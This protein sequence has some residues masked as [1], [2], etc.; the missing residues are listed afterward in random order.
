MNWVRGGGRHH[1]EQDEQEGNTATGMKWGQP[2][3]NDEES[4]RQSP[5]SEVARLRPGS[6]GSA[7]S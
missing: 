4:L 7:G 3:L 6:G 1:Q 2:L 5:L